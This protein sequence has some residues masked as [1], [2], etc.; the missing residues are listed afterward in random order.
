LRSAVTC[1]DAANR[2]EFSA[3][4]YTDRYSDRTG[5]LQPSAGP[6]TKASPRSPRTCGMHQA[7]SWRWPMDRHAGSWHGR[8]ADR[9]G[10]SCPRAAMAWR[11]RQPVSNRAASSRLWR[12]LV[13]AST[14]RSIMSGRPPKGEC[15]ILEPPQWQPL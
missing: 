12:A 4:N 6:P 14:P 15:G 7:R 9:I 13:G 5:K 10:G 1:A 11:R 2:D 3:E 8:Q